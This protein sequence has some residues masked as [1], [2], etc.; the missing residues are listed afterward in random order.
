MK[1]LMELDSPRFNLTWQEKL[2]Y[3]GFK[4]AAA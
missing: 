3:L 2:A 4:F 1:C